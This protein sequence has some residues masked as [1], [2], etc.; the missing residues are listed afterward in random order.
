[1]SDLT[2]LC[3][4]KWTQ[5]LTELG[6]LDSMALAGKQTACPMCG[7]RDRF[8]FSD[9][10]G[11]GLWHCRGCGKGG[12]G[13]HLIQEIRGIDF[14]RA[15]K[16]VESI[17][18]R[19]RWNRTRKRRPWQAPETP[20]PR[21]QSA[22]QAHRTTQGARVTTED[23]LRIWD[24]DGVDPR[25]T[26]AE[27]YLNSRR[28]K[29]SEDLANDVI[30]WSPARRAMFALMRTIETG[31]P[32]ALLLTLLETDGRKRF[33]TVN[34]RETCR[35]FCGPIAGAAIML[36][37]YESAL[38][39]NL[40]IGEGLETCMSA[41]HHGLRPCWAIGSASGLA[42][43]PLL[44]GT[45]RLTMLGE[46]GCA[47]NDRALQECGVRWEDAAREVRVIYSKTGKDLNDQLM[48]E[49]P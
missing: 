45:G 25:G 40:H 10:D 32:Q 17:V 7:G 8:H 41:Q 16:L 39:A 28:L 13:F 19:A 46:N 14:P 43:F 34:D 37:P 2:E 33:V 24:N 9:R 5:I 47:E 44:D 20:E 36:D 27:A 38:F 21:P 3:R 18:G 35:L 26:P 12:D 31:D 42:K 1:M 11:V 15:A 6:L 30:R 23:A 4:G 22:A 48:G 49:D 29:I